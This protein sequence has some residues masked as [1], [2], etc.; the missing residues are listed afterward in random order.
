MKFPFLDSLT[1]LVSGIGTSSDKAVGNQYA[2]RLLDQSQLDAAYR[3]D[4]VIRKAVNIPADDATREWRAWKAS[5]KQIEL[6]EEEEKRLCVQ[7]KVRS[8]MRKA[9]LHGGCAILIYIA[10]QDQSEP[11]NTERI[12]KLGADFLTVINRYDITAGPIVTDP[13]NV[14]YGKPEYYQITS[15]VHGVVRVHPSRLARFYGLE[16]PDH[17]QSTDGWGDSVIQAIDDTVKGLGTMTQGTASL[18]NEACVNVVKIPGFM[19]RVAHP[20]YR[21]K[22]LKRYQLAM[23]SKSMVN[24]LMLDAEEEYT[25][26]TY[27]FAG[28][29]PLMRTFM[30]LVAAA[31]DVPMARFLGAVP[32]S[33][34]AT[35]AGDLRNYYDNVSSVQRNE[36]G[37]ALSV[38]DEVLIRSALGNRPPKVF[39]EWRSL[40]QMSDTE[41]SEKNSKDVATV[42]AVYD[43]GLVQDDKLSVAFVNMLIE[44][45]LLPGLDESAAVDM[46]EPATTDPA[47]AGLDKENDDT[48][49][50]ADS[51]ADAD[52]DSDADGDADADADSGEEEED[53]Q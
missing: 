46:A 11:L 32:G 3:G 6:L 37:P 4:W 12:G 31:A 24:T 26:D 19:E 28:L 53:K 33:L 40:W 2:L 51:D 42:K 44:S 30:Q 18:V 48:D 52:A 35:G 22:L 21:D 13:L 14:A 47:E 36:I 7:Q 16:L 29:D 27:T 5:A 34:N 10:N 49:A 9:R 39:Y 45:G 15:P 23:V 38:L 8:A 1:N 50:D 43:T 25:K 41:R 17:N 20:D